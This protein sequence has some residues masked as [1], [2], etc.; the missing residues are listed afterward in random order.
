[1]A[2]NFYGAIT[3]IL[4]PFQ[5]TGAIDFALYSSW[6]DFQI[7]GGVTGIFVNGLASEAILLAPEEQTM[8]AEKTV[9]FLNGRAPVMGNVTSA[10]TATA[11]KI[12]RGYE[13]AGVDAVCITNPPVYPYDARS[14]LLHFEK[15]SQSTKLPVYIYNAPQSG[16]LMSP[17]I[18]AKIANENENVIGYKDSTL[19]FIHL[20][21]TLSQIRNGKRFE[22]FAGS[23][24]LILSTMQ[25]GGLGIISLLSAVFPRLIADLCN[26]ITLGNFKKALQL[27]LRVIRAREI[28][29]GGPYLAGYKF[30]S[31]LV[32]HSAGF[33]RMPLVDLSDTERNRI[34]KLLRDEHFI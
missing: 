5:A 19:D 9:K 4:T 14:L 18:I 29:K 15:A 24:A 21:S 7:E 33:L 28:L 2:A 17:A 32:G 31:C 26:E 10:C 23:D 1:M 6:L 34:E 13:A 20:Q 22:V 16:Y 12:V 25:L 3:D 27:Q 30:A 8:I 11:I